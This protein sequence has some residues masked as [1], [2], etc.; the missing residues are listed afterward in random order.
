[1]SEKRNDILTLS[2]ARLSFPKIFEKTKTSEE[3]QLKYSLSCLLDPNTAAGAENIKRVKAMQMRLAKTQWK[4]NAE[5]ILK[6]TE[7]DRRLLRPG[8]KATNA[9]GD[10]YAGYDGMVY[11]TASNTREIKV[12]NRD[13]SPAGK[14]DQEKFY[15]GCYADVVLSCYTIT[16]R[17]KGGNGI[18]AT[19][20]IVRWRGDG[21]PFGAAPLEE[22]DYLDDLE[23]DEEMGESGNS[24]AGGAEEEEMEDDLL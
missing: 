14:N 5:K 13:K 1:M 18:F 12:L 7:W 6:A 2:N 16:D 15:G 22:N 19:I 20:E 3:G 24:S 17:K 8:E 9:E 4:D 10:V 11:V 23:D 21:E